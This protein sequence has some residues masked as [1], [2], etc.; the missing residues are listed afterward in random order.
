MAEIT[1]V[2][3]IWTGRRGYTLA[4]AAVVAAAIARHTTMSYRF[5]VLSDHVPVRG[6]P[7]EV[8]PLP[9]ASAALVDVHHY[10]SSDYPACLPKLWLLSDE[11]R[12]L[13][14]RLFYVDADALITG[15]LAPIMAYAPEAPF[16]GM[17]LGGKL[18]VSMYL[19]TPGSHAWLWERFVRDE[20]APLRPPRCPQGDQQWMRRYMHPETFAQWPC[21]ALGIYGLKELEEGGYPTTLP[22][23]A[24]IIHPT[25]KVKPWHPRFADRHPWVKEYYPWTR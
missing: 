5:V 15:D 16:V 17:V 7:L 25:G 19:L 12:C 1:I 20:C 13:G 23:G 6:F 8:L 4:H 14:D 9:K 24:C 11:A 2:V 21:R 10:T 3:M 18:V 22:A